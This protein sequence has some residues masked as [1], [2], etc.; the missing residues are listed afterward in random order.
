MVLLVALNAVLCNNQTW[1]FQHRAVLHY[2]SIC[3]NVLADLVFDSQQRSTSHA[4]LFL[5]ASPLGSSGKSGAVMSFK[6]A[7]HMYKWKKD[8]F[9][10]LGQKG[11]LALQLPNWCLLPHLQTSGCMEQWGTCGPF[12]GLLPTG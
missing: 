6:D 2:G 4:V 7:V 12:V 5:Y 1:T 10:L 3:I 11:Q 8:L 9:A